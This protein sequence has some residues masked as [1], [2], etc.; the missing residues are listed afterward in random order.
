MHYD[1]L[2]F[3]SPTEFAPERH[4][5]S[6]SSVT[7]GYIDHKAFRPFERGP[8]ACIGQGLAID[9]IR[10]ILL[11]TVREFDF[12]CCAALRPNRKQRSPYTT[13]DLRL[14]DQVFQE[15]GLSSK[16]RDGMMV[17]VKRLYNPRT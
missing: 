9:E 4:L 2:L 5:S 6:V 10:V 3:D 8:R 14:G 13:L 11:L 16:P 15:I 1:P 7:S 12:E 17:S